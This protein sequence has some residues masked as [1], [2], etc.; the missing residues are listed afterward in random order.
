MHD[1]LEETENYT[2]ARACFPNA[3]GSGSSRVLVICDNLILEIQWLWINS[4]RDGKAELELVF[5]NYATMWYPEI[6][7]QHEIQEYPDHW[8][9][10]CVEVPPDLLLI[11]KQSG[12]ELRYSCMILFKKV[13][14]QIMTLWELFLS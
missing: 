13:Y 4:F 2:S 12:E 11:S 7:I 3:I 9:L 1:Q 5:M 8:P 10:S 6:E 14:F